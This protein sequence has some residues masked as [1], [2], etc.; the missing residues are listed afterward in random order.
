MYYLQ[1]CGKDSPKIFFAIV[2]GTNDNV[3]LMAL[4]PCDSDKGQKRNFVLFY[5]YF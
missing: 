1:Y 3:S 2:I 4:I 5:I